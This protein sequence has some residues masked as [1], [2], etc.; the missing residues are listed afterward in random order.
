MVDLFG[1]IISG[2]KGRCK[3][4]FRVTL[5]LSPGIYAGESEAV[6]FCQTT[7]IFKMEL[8]PVFCRGEPGGAVGLATER[9]TP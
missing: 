7:K 3:T 5:S 1:G 8:L 9:A 4:P 6:T 2:F